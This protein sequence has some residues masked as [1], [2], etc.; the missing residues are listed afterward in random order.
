[1]QFDTPLI[2]ATLL[3]RY[4][5]FLFDARLEDGS[6]ITGFCPNTGRLAGLSDPGSRIWLSIHD[7]LGRKYRYAFEMVEVQGEMAGI[8]SAFANRIALEAIKAGLLPALCGYRSILAEQRY[9]LRSRVDFLLKDGVK[10]GQSLADAYVEVKNVNYS[11]TPGLAEF[12][13]TPTARG[14][15]HLEELGAVAE[16]GHRAVMI[17]VV[18]RHD[19]SRLRICAESDPA[20]AAAFLRAKARGVEAYALRCRVSPQEIVACGLVEMDEQATAAL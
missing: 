3:K 11:R 1:M 14:A 8:H 7:G 6:E 18:Q 9:G 13:H 2:P 20:Y 5:R 16:A 4:K 15:R 17:Y 19:C 12:P 10:D